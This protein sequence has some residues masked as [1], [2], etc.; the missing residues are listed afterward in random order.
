MQH[1]L[2]RRNSHP[3]S[4]GCPAILDHVT[5]RLQTPMHAIAIVSVLL[6]AGCNAQPATAPTTKPTPIVQPHGDRTNLDGFVKDEVPVYPSPVPG[7]PVDSATNTPL[8]PRKWTLLPGTKIKAICQVIFPEIN[9]GSSGLYVT[10]A[11][12]QYGYIED[13]VE[14]TTRT[15]DTNEQISTWDLKPC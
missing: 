4:S 6:S 13:R 7:Q 14:I 9:P 11:P 15:T 10:W 8:P 3:E 1:R 12:D 2:R 5:S